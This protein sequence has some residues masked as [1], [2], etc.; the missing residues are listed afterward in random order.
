MYGYIVN[1]K[2]FKN[3]FVFFPLGL[4]A[5]FFLQDRT[6]QNKTEFIVLPKNKHTIDVSTELIGP[7][8]IEKP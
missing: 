6:E 3:F 5:E 1:L 7:G 8:S 2:K 4:K